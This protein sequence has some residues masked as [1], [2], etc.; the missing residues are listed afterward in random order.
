MRYFF[1]ILILFSRP[2]FGQLKSPESCTILVQKSVG[3]IVLDGRLDEASWMGAQVATRFVQNFPFDTSFAIAQTDV[4]LTYSESALYISAV[5]YDSIK[6]DFIVQSLRRD[7]DY[8]QTENFTVYL[9]P[10]SN[11]TTGFA[12]SVSPLGVMR[13]GLL[14]FGGSFGTQTNWDNKWS[15]EVRVEAGKWITEI[16]IPFNTLRFKSGTKTWRVNFSRNNLKVNENASWSPVPRNFSVSALA[17]TGTLVWESPPENKSLNLALIP[18]TNS[19]TTQSFQR[20]ETP[21]HAFNY[22]ADAKF[23]VTSSLNLDLTINPDFSQ[24]DVD[25]QITNLERFSIFFPEQRQF[26]LENGDLFSNFGFSRIRPFFSRRIGLFDGEQVPIRAGARLS[27]NLNNDLRL[28]LLNIQTD[29]AETASGIQLTPQNYT[30]VSLQQKVFTRSN[31]SAIYVGR[32]GRDF[33]GQSGNNFNRV[34]GVDYN[35]LSADGRWFGRLF[36]HHNFTPVS[37]QQQY[38]TA[39]FL[40][41]DEPAFALEW[42]HEVI[43]ANYNPEVGFVPRNNVVRFEPIATK[44]FFPKSELINNHGLTVRGDIYRSLNES[45]LLDQ[46]I[47]ATYFLNFQNTAELELYAARQ[48]TKL[49]FPFD[50]TGRDEMPLPIGGYTFSVVG[51]EFTSDLRPVLTY[52]AFI[53]GGSYFNGTRREYGG[54]VQYRFQPYGSIQVSVNQTDID[55][56][57]PFRDA[58]LTLLGTRLDLSLTRALFIT[59]FLQYNTQIENV[60]LNARLQWRFA[61][62]SDIFVVLT[63]NYNTGN[64]AVRSRGFVVKV[65]YWFNT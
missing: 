59:G 51:A 52:G 58:Q 56:P 40:R 24:V 62:M 26:F 16:E 29:A 9:D 17:F 12:F 39:L 57:E 3:E 47:E 61:P 38:A 7:F 32:E 45:T 2:I 46:L 44:R 8:P 43:G 10:L 11:Q 15:A 6:G 60:N 37:K 42:N 20:Q 33:N 41:Y 14:D 34:V 25:R 48:F 5:C 30:V 27:G 64:F 55:L 13:E 53:Y 35:L 4:R 63:D 31:L 18:Y 23:A 19:T 21:E 22:G 54:S 1:F 50:V 49:F 65:S 28:G 36:Y